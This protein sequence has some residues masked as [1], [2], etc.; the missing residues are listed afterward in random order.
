MTDGKGRGAR[1]AVY[2]LSAIALVT[3]AS[4]WAGTTVPG[5]GQAKSD[6][7]VVLN[8]SGSGAFTAPSTVTCTDGDPSCDQDGACND[9]CT[10]RV[11]L[12]VNQ[13]GLPACVAPLSLDS[14]KPG[15][16]PPPGLIGENCG[17]FVDKTVQVRT[18]RN[19]KRP[20]KLKIKAQGKAPKGTKPRVDKDTY[21]LVCQPRKCGTPGTAHLLQGATTPH[22][23]AALRHSSA[24]LSS[25]NWYVS[26]DKI[27]IK[28]TR[29]NFAGA[30]QQDSTDADLVDCVVT[31]DRAAATL[32]PLLDCPFSIG[33]GTYT[34]M[35]LFV[36][37]TS[38][39]LISDATNGLYTDPS[40][41]TKLS[42]TAPADGAAFVPVTATLGTAFQ[43]F[44]STPLVVTDQPV[45]LSVVIDAVQTVQLTSS[46]GTPPTFGTYF[47]AYVFPSIG[48]VGKP[49][50]YTSSGTA[51]T[52]DDST[53]LANIIR[54]YYEPN[55]APT[56]SLFQ[57]RGM[58][59]MGCADGAYG[60]G[61]H[62]ADNRTTPV[63]ND[64]SR[65]G[66][67]LGLDSTNTMCWVYAG[68]QAFSTYSNYLTMGKVPNIGD[69]TTL[70]CAQTTSPTPP[71]SGS[72]YAS[73]CPPM[74]NQFVAVPM[75]LVAD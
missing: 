52:Y 48:G 1:V 41:P 56:Y 23:A 30:T 62:A 11:R 33:P 32:A 60:I 28:L 67:W 38:E 50:Y 21:V 20:G 31:Y 40:A 54:V 5:G 26:P 10:F 39:V 47:P 16:L 8:A 36:D 68:D 61:A 51:D 29:I 69:S 34:S 57:Q 42:S 2:T 9:S 35:N 75:T 43:Q 63:N 6:C 64:G 25:G 19:R 24:G 18:R 53:V 66:G 14:V 55:G 71:S 27:K 12:C 74:T 13:P 37:P 58:S 4:A 72:T 17:S 70:R 15:S 49:Q 7:Y 59:L 73:G 65:P 22:S 45:S 44:F 3:M 46:G